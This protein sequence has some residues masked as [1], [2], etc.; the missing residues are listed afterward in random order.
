MKITIWLYFFIISDGWEHV[1][2]EIGILYKMDAK[3][4]AGDCTQVKKWKV[5]CVEIL[6]YNGY[7]KL[8]R[9]GQQITRRKIKQW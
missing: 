9:K 8:T 7:R 2:N 6:N 1:N 3:L 4:L 5:I